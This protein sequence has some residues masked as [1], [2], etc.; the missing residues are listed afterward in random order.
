MTHE[1]LEPCPFCGGKVF[2]IPFGQHH[3]AIE[4]HN[5]VIGPGVELFGKAEAETHWNTRPPNPLQAEVETLRARVAELEGELGVF[6][7][8]LGASIAIKQ[9]EPK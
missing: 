2:T 3:W 5:C 6:K 7:S 9:E 4:C 1:A 8:V